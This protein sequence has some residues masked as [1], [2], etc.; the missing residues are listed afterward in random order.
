MG[1]VYKAF[2]P[3]IRAHGRD[4]DHPQG[5][6]RGRSRPFAVLARFKNEAQAA[7]RLHHPGIV[8]VYEYGEDGDFAYIAMEYVEGNSLREYL[9]R[10]TRFDDP[11]QS[12]SIMAQL[13]DA[14]ALR[15]RAAASWHRDIKPANL[16]VM[17]NGRLKVADF[18]IA[19][20]DSLE[21]HADRRGDGHAGVHGAR[22]VRR[23]ATSTSAPTSSPRRGA[24]PAAGGRQAVRAAAPKRSP[25]R[26]ATSTRRC[27]RRST[28]GACRRLTMRWSQRRS[29]RSP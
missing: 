12:S 7:G 21:P 11:R 10:G 13:L 27:P 29:R 3:D 28:W 9:N 25:T 19:R 6:D 1:V 20:I 18:G 14:L 24:V 26:S 8:G 15:A 2:D 22:A 4:Q 23:A 16:I 17:T 5:T